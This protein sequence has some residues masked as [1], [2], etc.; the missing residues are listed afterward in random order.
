MTLRGFYRQVAV[1]VI[2]TRDAALTGFERSDFFASADKPSSA[3]MRALA[4]L[5]HHFK[6]RPIGLDPTCHE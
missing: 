3:A 5:F 1:L 6:F 4:S 2:V